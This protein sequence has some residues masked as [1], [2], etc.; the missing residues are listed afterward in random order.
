VRAAIGDALRGPVVR[1]APAWYEAGVSSEPIDLSHVVHDGLVTYRGL[2]APV[3][4]DFMTREAPRA[5]YAEGT[6]F[7]IGRI[8]MV[9]NT[10]TYIDAPFHRFADGKDLAELPLSSLADLDGV[11]VRHELACGRAIGP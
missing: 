9:A 11:V 1:R 2:P 7:H 6:T 10:G 8:D 4:C 3:V 5:H